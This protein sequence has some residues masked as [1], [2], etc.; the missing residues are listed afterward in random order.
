MAVFSSDVAKLW[1]SFWV[2]SAVSWFAPEASVTSLSTLY[3]S[4]SRNHAAQGI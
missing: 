3:G 1:V 4:S 2:Q